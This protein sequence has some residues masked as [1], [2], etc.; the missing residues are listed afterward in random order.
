MALCPSIPGLILQSG[1]VYGNSEIFCD[2]RGFVF[3]VLYA[4]S[5]LKLYCDAFLRVCQNYIWYSL[6]SCYIYICIY[7][8]IC[9]Y[10]YL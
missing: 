3:V 9:L 2:S 6:F 4:R 10:V 1:E 8:C 7:A 5:D